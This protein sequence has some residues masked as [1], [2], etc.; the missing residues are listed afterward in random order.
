MDTISSIEGVT[1]IG[2]ERI[3]EVLPHRPPFLFVE[4]LIDIV[5]GESATGVKTVSSNE[6][7]F[8]GHFPKKP[9]MPGV[10]IVEAMAQTAA[11]LVMHSLDWPIERLRTSVVYFM[12]MD[13]CRF[14]RPVFPGSVLY[15]PVTRIHTRGRVWKFQGL[16]RVDGITVAEARYTA[17]ISDR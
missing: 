4:R 17:M 11:A 8:R 2:L 6:D 13:T 10:L 1:E 16:A 7:F 5:P 9:V 12:S 14:R 3:N 15:L